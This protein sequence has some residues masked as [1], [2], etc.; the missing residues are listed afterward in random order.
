MKKK[1]AKVDELFLRFCIDN[2]Q[3]NRH[4]NGQTNKAK[5]IGYIH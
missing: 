4:N 5:I 1:S 3:I 2:G